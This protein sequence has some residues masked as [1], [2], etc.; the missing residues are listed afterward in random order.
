MTIIDCSQI[1]MVRNSPCRSHAENDINLQTLLQTLFK[2]S[3]ETVGLR[4][5]TE[6]QKSYRQGRA[7]VRPC[8]FIICSM[9]NW[10][11]TNLKKNY[12]SYP[13]VKDFKVL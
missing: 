9:Y 8:L 5:N 12:S 6:T 3:T 7:I 2:K 4:P 13:T 1:I 10:G 11:N